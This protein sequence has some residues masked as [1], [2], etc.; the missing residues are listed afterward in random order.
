[1]FSCR[2]LALALLSAAACSSSSSSSPSSGPPPIR[3]TDYNQSCQTVADC[4]LINQGDVCGCPGCGNAA[5]NASDQSRYESDYNSR[6]QLC[7]PPQACPA[8]CMLVYP[9]CVG[10]KCGVCG[11]PGCNAS[12]GGVDGG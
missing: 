3:A 12:D 5:I 9:T 10:G 8:S 4:V 6:K 7:G 2:I 11:T 1:M